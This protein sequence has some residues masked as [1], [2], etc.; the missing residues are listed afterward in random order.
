MNAAVS[1]ATL[2]AHQLRQGHIR[3]M[4][5]DMLGYLEYLAP[6]GDFLQIPLGWA[7][8]A[9][10]INHP[11][12]IQEVLLKQARQFH[13]PFTVKYAARGLFGEN[14]FTSDDELWQVLRSSLQPAFHARRIAV[15]AQ[16]MLDYTQTMVAGWQAG[17]ILDMPAALMDLTLGI[18]TK[19]LFDQ[20]LRNAEAAAAILRFIDLFA[21]RITSLPIPGW[22][23][24]P[25]NWE[26]K[27]QI[28]IIDRHLSPLIADRR[29]SGNDLGDVLSMLI[30]A[31]KADTTGFLTDQQVRNEVLNLF[32]AG[33]EVTAHTLAFTLYL[34]AQ[35]PAVEVRLV[36]EIRQTLGSR[37]I[38]LADL[39][40]LPY[41]DQVL[42][43]SM[44][45]L[46]VT[47]V[48]SRQTL[49]P[50][51][52]GDTTLPKN[53]LVLIAPWILHR[54][55]DL[56]P[57]PLRFDPDR[58]QAERME[59]IPKFAY[60]PFSA[61][62]RVCIGQAFAML[63]LRINLATILQ[64][65]RLMLLSD[66]QFQPFFRFNTRPKQGLP[67]RLQPRA[68]INHSQPE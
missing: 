29:R 60:L 49:A 55:P 45:L 39:E 64:H 34:I 33:Y 15:S 19:A 50:V 57:D 25:S 31:Q 65:Y 22:L 14:L 56:F 54:R 38:T 66:Y 63:Q 11:D 13:K 9:Y 26:M 16:V 3:A 53:R 61:G 20:D 10:L 30:Q 41:L 4:Q 52:L 43:E 46:P 68:V 44:R 42:K 36:D 1:T 12:L 58:F 62:P 51:T 23:P 47:A 24:I 35:H 6:Q 8:A 27:R 67:M 7:G 37:P 32:A 28:A 59:A 17:Q 18:T 21:Q 40:Q 2:P 48:V 5:Q